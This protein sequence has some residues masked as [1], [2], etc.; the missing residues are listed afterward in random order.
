MGVREPIFEYACDD[1]RARRFAGWI[2][3]GKGAVL[4]MGALRIRPE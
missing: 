3:A 4:G 2:H 1:A